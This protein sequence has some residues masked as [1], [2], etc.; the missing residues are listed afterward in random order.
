MI[1]WQDNLPFVSQDKKTS[2]GKNMFN[3]S[4]VGLSFPIKKF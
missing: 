4:Y 1:D 2:Y 3:R